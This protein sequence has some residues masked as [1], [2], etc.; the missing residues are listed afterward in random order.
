MSA[1][2]VMRELRGKDFEHGLVHGTGAS[3]SMYGVAM[4]LERRA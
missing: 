3:L 2:S 4:V 1:W